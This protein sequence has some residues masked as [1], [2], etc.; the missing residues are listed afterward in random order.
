MHARIRLSRLRDIGWRCWDP[1]GLGA[2]DDWEK[3]AA[4]G[5]YD[6]YLLSVARMLRHNESDETC[7]QYLLRAE[8]ENLRLGARADAR[9]RADATIAAIRGDDQL[10]MD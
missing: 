3:S 6:V 1:M 10:W 4:G 5:E 9:A 2:S 7:A 8:S